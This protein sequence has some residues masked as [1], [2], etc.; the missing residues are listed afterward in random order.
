M[1]PVAFAEAT[2]M[3][4]P[5]GGCEDEVVQLPV[6]RTGGTIVSC[7]RPSPA[8]LAEII[9]TGVVWLA[10][11]GRETQPPVLLSGHKADVI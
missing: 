10:V 5:P 2:T 3:L 4:G 11:W 7:W 1:T 6:R 9:R 8:E